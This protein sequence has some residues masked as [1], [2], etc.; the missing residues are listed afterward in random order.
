MED[1]YHC[2]LDG[3]HS[4]LVVFAIIKCRE[5]CCTRVGGMV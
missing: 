4:G 5:S 3:V 1:G 2:A